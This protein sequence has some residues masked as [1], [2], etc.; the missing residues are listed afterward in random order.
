[1]FSDKKWVLVGALVLAAALALAAC[2]PAAPVTVFVT[3]EGEQ[4]VVTA[5]PAPPEAGPVRDTIVICMGQEPDT[6]YGITGSMAVRQEVAAAF[7]GRGWFYDTAYFY[8]TQMLE[9]DEFPSFENGGATLEDDVLSVTYKFKDGITWSDGEPFTVDDVLFT[10]DVLLD[11]NSGATTT[12]SYGTYTWEKVDDLTFKVTY[13][14]GAKNPTYFLPPVSG[15]ADLAELLPKHVL[16]NTAPADIIT[17]DYA[18]KPDPVLGPYK[19]TDW[20]EGDHISLDAVENWWGGEIKVPHLVYRFIPDSNQMMA[21]LLSGECDLGTSD[22]LNSTQVPFLQQSAS[23]GLIAFTAAP[24]TTWEHLDLN[25]YP[26]DTGKPTTKFPFFADPRVR[27]AVAY[28]VN[29]QQMTEE[30]LFGEVQPLNSFLPSDHWAYDPSLDGKYAFDADKAKSLLAE[31]GWEDKDADGTVEAQSALTGDFSCGRG[32][33]NI[34]A[35]TPFDVTMWIPATP[36]FRGQISTIVQSNLKDVGINVTLNTV[37]AATMFAD[38]GPLYVRTPDIFEFAFQTSPDPGSTPAG[39]QGENIYGWDPAVLT[40]LQPSETGP[41]LVASKILEQKPDILDGTG[42]TEEMFKFG[43]ALAADSETPPN[44]ANSE[45]GADKLPAGMIQASP[46]QVPETRNNLGGQNNPGYCNEDF[47]Q[48]TWDGGNV[49][50]PKDRT[51][52]YQKAQQ[53]FMEDVPVVPLFQRLIVV[54]WVKDLC[55]VQPGPAN[56]PP[57]NIETWYFAN[58]GEECPASE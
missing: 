34:P 20:V 12:G 43:R 46:G 2:A 38:G 51:P 17:S 25:N 54:G 56:Y 19:V 3:Q 23:R 35:G 42:I 48:A 4:V 58:A 55:N 31:A 44:A 8:A 29:R 47:D 57:W 49:L 18:R 40:D 39:Y 7:A 10:K 13:P 30:I 22:V 28:A 52:F 1:M 24:G 14:K 27:Q 37:P 5:T 9:N 11:P 36:S 21:S 16:E 45:F 15:P 6:L 41:F 50:E 53:I 26:V 32:T 33:W